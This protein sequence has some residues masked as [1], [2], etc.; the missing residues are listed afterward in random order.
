MISWGNID[1]NADLGEG[2]Q[3]EELLMPFINS[4]SIACGGHYGD[5][6]TFIKTATA[7]KKHQL[8]IGAHPSYPDKLNFGRKAM[9]MDDEDLSKSIQSQI[10]M[11]IQCSD[12]IGIELSHI[13]LHGAL[14]NIAAK[15]EKIARL[16][17]KAIHS[18]KRAFILYTLPH[19][20]LSELASNYM[21]VKQEAFLDRAYNADGSL[22]DR[23]VNGAILTEKEQV[24][25]QLKSIYLHQTVDTVQ[26]EAISLAA[27]TFCIHGDQ[28]GALEQL[29]FIHEQISARHE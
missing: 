5:R 1:I 16:V 29:R 7:A 21:I 20:V 27:E 4:C 9:Q 3:H 14:Y 26:G 17:L 12:Q 24:W 23:S 10:G 22:C 25:Q 11:A 8:K 18:F 19:S 2:V 6:Y 15:D 28:P 13:K